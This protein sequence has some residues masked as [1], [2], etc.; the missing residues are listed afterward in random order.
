[1]SG[2]PAAA[3]DAV[4]AAAVQAHRD[5]R[6]E[7]ARH[8]YDTVL[9]LAPEHGWANYFRG[10]VAEHD[11]DPA[12][13]IRHFRRAVAAAQG[14]VQA[15]IALGNAELAAG[16]PQDALKAFE[17]AIARRPRLAAAHTGKALALKQ[18]GRLE[19][20]AKAGTEALRLRRGGQPGQAEPEGELDPA[21][22]AEMR[23]ANRIKLLHDAAQL[24]YLHRLGRL[25]DRA[26][27]IAAGCEELARELPPP[28][29]DT[30]IVDLDEP[31]LRRTQFA[32]NRLLWLPEARMPTDGAL[33]RATDF[34]AADETFAASRPLPVVIDD[35][36]SAEALRRLQ[37]FCREAT[38]WFEVKD[39]GGH[40]GAYFEEGLACDLLVGIARQLQAALPQ[41][42][43][44][45]RLVQLWAYKHSPDGTGTDL[46]A[47]IGTVSAN[48]WIAPDQSPADGGGGME[49]WPQRLP[50][51]WDFR[52]AN[53]ERDGIRQLLAR[54]GEAP[55]TI[56]YR[57]N[58]LVLFGANLFHR[59][60]P[61]A[62][63]A[64]YEQRRINI[65]FLF[66]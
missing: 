61:G 23:R 53:V 7:E 66:N 22:R 19:D 29:A 49:I 10:L 36:L 5:G 9:A 38:I 14:P 64:A 54:S 39:H 16:Q 55:R 62:F 43:G 51:D 35:V 3:L 59:S 21:E 40:L 42:L 63:P 44:A 6:L 8:G 27:Q 48:L 18:G 45:L 52:R 11:A 20:A 57:C 32:Y 17:A 58:R 26:L 15:C 56:P 33:D 2:A 31:A 13:A 41:T 4:L 37:A 30:A 12:M 34:A 46:H 47:D 25:D 65:T 24:R 28:P 50:D 1:M 60:C